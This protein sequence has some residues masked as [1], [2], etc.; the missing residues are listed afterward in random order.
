MKE[1]N[2]YLKENHRIGQYVFMIFSQKGSERDLLKDYEG[3][4][5]TSTN[6][7]YISKNIR[8]W[9]I[10]CVYKGASSSVHEKCFKNNQKLNWKYAKI[11]VPDFLRICTFDFSKFFRFEIDEKGR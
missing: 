1:I 10:Y 2:K 11:D 7:I 8:K 9:S 3:T 4:V 5:L 6:R